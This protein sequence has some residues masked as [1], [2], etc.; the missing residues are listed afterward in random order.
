MI[1][2][3][4]IQSSFEDVLNT[5]KVKNKFEIFDENKKNTIKRDI[6]ELLCFVLKIDKSKLISIKKNK[7]EEENIIFFKSLLN[8]LK[9][10]KPIEYITHNACFFGYNFFVNESCLIPRVDSEVLVEKAIEFIKKKLNSFKDKKISILDACCG[11]GCLGLSFVKKISEKYQKY[12]IDFTLNLLDKST[13][14]IQVSKIN[15]EKL[16]IKKENVFYTISDVLQNGFG[17]LKY[18]IIFFNPPYINTKT[19]ECLDTSVKDFEPRIAL[20]GG[21]DGL[22]FYKSISNSFLKN[23]SKNGSCFFEFGYNQKDEILKIFGKI[24]SK[25]YD[26]QI[27]KD[28][29]DNDRCLIIATK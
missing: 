14:A 6:E 8:D 28:Y 7:I 15:T 20:D 17:S 11:S 18:D 27:I 22:K 10:E 13:Q 12:G 16:N 21:D 24:K 29:G 25:F 9:N 2:Q 3:E 1:I 5:I 23:L 26:L 19:I 4:L